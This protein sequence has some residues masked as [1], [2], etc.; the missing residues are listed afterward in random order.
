MQAEAGG[1]EFNIH[2]DTLNCRKDWMLF[3]RNWTKLVELIYSKRSHDL[4][5]IY[6]TDTVHC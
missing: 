2:D 3:S 6:A 4:G 5:F 1:D